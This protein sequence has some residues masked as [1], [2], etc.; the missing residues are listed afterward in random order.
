MAQAKENVAYDL[1][2]FEPRENRAEEQT[3]AAAVKK[4]QAVRKPSVRP[5]AVLK[6]S[7]ASLLVLLSLTAVMLGN[8]QINKLNNQAN[9]MRKQ[10]SNAQSEQIRLSV[11]LE[12]RTSLSNVENYAVNK[13]GLQK[14]GQY[15]IQYV[16]LADKDKVEVSPE[17]RNIFVRLYNFILEY[18]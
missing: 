15:Q 16:H 13:L 18:L 6:W 1:S 5:L 10:M 3:E 7:A 12:S 8:V 11:S 2:L 4:Q 14:I 17:S 9:T